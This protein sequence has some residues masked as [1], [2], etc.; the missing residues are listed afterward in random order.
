MCARVV[1]RGVAR[2]ATGSGPVSTRIQT[3][4]A[5]PDAGARFAGLSD[6]VIVEINVCVVKLRI[7]RKNSLKKNDLQFV[8]G[9]N[10]T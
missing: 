1:G 3:S 9:K 2:S 7:L 10:E 5:A 8:T 4:V 6:H